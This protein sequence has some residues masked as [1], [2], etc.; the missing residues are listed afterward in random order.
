MIS[1][2]PLLLIFALM[3]AYP[4][5][6]QWKLAFN[7]NADDGHSFS[8]RATA[9][10]D[11]TNV[12]NSTSAFTADYKSLNVT[13]EIA[14][15][16]AIVRHQ[17]GE[18]EAVKV[19]EFLTQGNKLRDYL[20]TAKTNSLV[21]T[22]N[23]TYTYTS[24][25]MLDREKDP[26]FAV[27]GALTFN[28]RWHDNGV[29]IGN[30]GL[31]NGGLPKTG[32][33]DDYNGLG[34]EYS[35]NWNNYWSDVGV[36]QDYCQAANYNAQG[37]DHGIFMKGS[38]LLGQYA[39]YVSDSTTIFSCSK[40]QVSILDTVAIGFDRADRTE[41]GFLTFEEF[42]FDFTDKNGDGVISILEYT[43]ARARDDLGETATGDDFMLDF[44]RIDT[45]GDAMVSFGEFLFDTID[46]DKDR[47]ISPNE[48]AHEHANGF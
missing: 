8:Y 42:I 33:T 27:D 24:P 23:N 13:H 48:Y 7:I 44:N 25:S 15:F 39:V 4:D 16:I 38:K 3:S 30:S 1:T 43:E 14:N 37:S 2:S 9:W 22:Y 32:T 28:W 5:D 6:V 12:G 45:D 20:D 41:S 18:C 21:A 34:N 47:V 19:W 17:D 46:F 35:A 29:R 10:E 11:D 36:N 40:L 31:C 26:I